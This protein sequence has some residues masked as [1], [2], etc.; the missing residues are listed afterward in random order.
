MTAAEPYISDDRWNG[1]GWGQRVAGRCPACGRNNTLFVAAGQHITC[2][3]LPCPNPTAVADFLLGE[4][5]TLPAM[6]PGDSVREND[7]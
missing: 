3:Y 7:R 1:H 4:V 2:S 5:A 6:L